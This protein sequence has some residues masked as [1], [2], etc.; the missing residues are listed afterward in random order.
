VLQN[1]KTFKK[2]GNFYFIDSTIKDP[3]GFIDDEYAFFANSNDGTSVQSGVQV[4]NWQPV[5][6]G[7]ETTKDLTPFVR[8]AVDS[9]LSSYMA[10]THRKPDGLHFFIDPNLPKSQKLLEQIDLANKYRNI[11]GKIFDNCGYL[12]RGAIN[13][14]RHNNSN[15]KIYYTD[16]K[17][18]LDNIINELKENGVYFDALFRKIYLSEIEDLESRWR[19]NIFTDTSDP[20]TRE[21]NLYRNYK[22]KIIKQHAPPPVKTPKR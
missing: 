13:L 9:M 19:S 17:K 1:S 6:S 3:Y 2:D 18:E 21:L 20:D 16:R 5:I 10:S 11:V 15:N 12:A 8:E 22:R 4:T 14:N 7:I